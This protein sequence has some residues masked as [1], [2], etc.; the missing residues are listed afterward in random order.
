MSETESQIENQTDTKPKSNTLLCALYQKKWIIGSSAL[1]VF[2][3]EHFF[4]LN[5]ISIRPT[6]LINY[7]NTYSRTWFNTIGQLAAHV[8]SYLIRL[9]FPEVTKTLGDIASSLFDFFTSGF[10]VFKGYITT[11][12]TQYISNTGLIYLGSFLL[13]VGM[14]YGVFRFYNRKSKSSK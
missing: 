14:V 1:A 11:A 6:V 3:W 4:R 12:T 8:S 7:V 5:D 9:N 13:T 10:H 2:L